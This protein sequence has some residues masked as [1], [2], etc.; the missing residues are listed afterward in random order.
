MS[1]RSCTSEK[2]KEF[3]SE[4]SIHF[5]GLKGLDKGTVLVFPR[6]VVCTNCGFT[7]FIIPDAE[8]HRLKEPDAVQR[9]Q[10]PGGS[11]LRQNG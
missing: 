6:L 4:I 10:I 9:P 11:S 7:E 3:G 5:P 1:C 2:Q 8:L